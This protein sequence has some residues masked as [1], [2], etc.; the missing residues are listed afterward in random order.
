MKTSVYCVAAGATA[1]CTSHFTLR[2]C[3]VRHQRATESNSSARRQA[4]Y[5]HRLGQRA[6]SAGLDKQRVPTSQETETGT[7][8]PAL[9]SCSHCLQSA[10]HGLD[11]QLR[12][13]SSHGQQCMGKEPQHT[14][15]YTS[16]YLNTL[17]RLYLELPQHTRQLCRCSVAMATAAVVSL[18][19]RAGGMRQRI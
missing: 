13:L 9:S 5:L 18:L 7:A 12:R 19:H 10:P 17:F 2:T 4:G 14:S 16:S 11:S 8:G 15:G 1:D 3:L 6:A